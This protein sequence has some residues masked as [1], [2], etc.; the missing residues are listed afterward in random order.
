MSATQSDQ[1][2]LSYMNQDSQWLLAQSD[3]S[4]SEEKIKDRIS[5]S[6]KSA[7][8]ALECHDKEIS[9]SHQNTESW[10]PPSCR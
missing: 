3:P 2:G 8:Q 10:V 5:L 4:S 1:L 9:I 7:Y 6:T